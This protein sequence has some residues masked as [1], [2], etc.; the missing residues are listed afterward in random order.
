MLRAAG[1]LL[2]DVTTMY[3]ARRLNRISTE[4]ATVLV[5]VARYKR[6]QPAR[7]FLIGTSFT[8]RRYNGFCLQAHL[9]LHRDVPLLRDVA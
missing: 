5:T 6:A 1:Q 3:L 4:K 2:G 9:S 7:T 8:G